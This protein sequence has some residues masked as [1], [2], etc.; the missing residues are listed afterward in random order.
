[1]LV[2]HLSSVNRGADNCERY[3]PEF[4]EICWGDTCGVPALAEVGGTV[5][6]GVC[7]CHSGLSC[8]GVDWGWPSAVST[9][10]SALEGGLS[11][12][13]GPAV[14]CEEVGLG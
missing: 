4:C 11:P 6:A 13:K 3:E 9:T 1:M 14:D 10:G 12:A 7:C 8:G 2:L 5:C